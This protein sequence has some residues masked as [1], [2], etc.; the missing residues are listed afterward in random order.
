MVHHLHV[1]ICKGILERHP[2]IFLCT[3][4][5]YIYQYLWTNIYGTQN[6]ITIIS[7]IIQHLKPSGWIPMIHGCGSG[8]VE[9]PG[10]KFM[11]SLRFSRERC[12][13]FLWILCLRNISTWTTS[14]K[15][16][17]SWIFFLGGSIFHMFFQ[18]K[19]IRCLM[20]CVFG[21]FF[22]WRL[23]YSTRSSSRPFK[24]CWHVVSSSPMRTDRFSG[25]LNVVAVLQTWLH[26]QNHQ[27][28]YIYVYIHTC[29]HV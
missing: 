4:Y 24:S 29:V 10:W 9:G 3:V 16:V 12:G 1:L 25:A 26:H 2:S 6:L 23:F 18:S 17:V 22:G 20:I 13:L 15:H 19:K 28:I 7:F 27:Y 11:R 21:A 14:K 5:I 8:R